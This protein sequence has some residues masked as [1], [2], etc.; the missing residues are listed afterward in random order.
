M[1]GQRKLSISSV[2][3][4]QNHPILGL[5]FL[6]L[7]SVYYKWISSLVLVGSEEA[8][9]CFD[10]YFH[11][12]N[13]SFIISTPLLLLHLHVS[14]SSYSLVL[15]FVSSFI[16]LTWLFLLHLLIFISSTS[17][18]LPFTYSFV[19]SASLFILHFCIPISSSSLLLA[20]IHC[21]NGSHWDRKSEPLFDNNGSHC[22]FTKQA[23]L[24]KA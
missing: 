12:F 7:F 14:I 1:N 20:S 16:I 24:E 4:A 5:L 9:C 18:L 10:E 22:L 2:P 8:F 15:T 23:F 17:P 21:D 11:P 6:P 19:I 3:W 13:S